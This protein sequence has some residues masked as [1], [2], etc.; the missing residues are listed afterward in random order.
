[1]KIINL[2]QK[3]KQHPDKLVIITGLSLFVTFLFMLFNCFLGIRYSDEFAVSIAIYYGCL[4]LARIVSVICEVNLSDRIEEQK[5]KKRK[6][7]YFAL[8]IFMFFI[9]LCLIAPIFLM[10]FRPKDVSFGII[11][12]ITMATY[13]TYKITVAILN[14]NR[15]RKLDN[16]T[17][18]FLRELAVIDASVSVLSLQH[19]LIMVNG[20]MTA[21]MKI[22]S[23]IS[24]LIIVVV[25]I[26]FSIISMKIT[27]KTKK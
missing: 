8:S 10:V 12:A 15:S 9:D 23:L 18:K 14:F 2:F 3:L 7:V 13:T 4:I 11:P 17:Y 16:L 19:T 21:S 27:L 1:M 6:Q 22:L 26:C 24:S 25:I 5:Y 20:G